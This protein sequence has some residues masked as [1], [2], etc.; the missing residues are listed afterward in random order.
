MTSDENIA[1]DVPLT[2]IPGYMGW[3]K[4]RL[5]SGESEALIAHLDATCMWGTPDD[6][7]EISESDFQ[8]M[9]DDLKKEL[10]NEGL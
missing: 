3:S 7:A 4:Q 2:Q 1:R 9:L 5:H 10:G 8:E 6:L